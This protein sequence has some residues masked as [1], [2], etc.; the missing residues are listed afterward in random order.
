MVHGYAYTYISMCINA[1]T[2]TQWF[3]SI[4][5]NAEKKGCLLLEYL[6]AC[7]IRQ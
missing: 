6:A 1:K 3:V 7:F 4:H 2:R 5:A